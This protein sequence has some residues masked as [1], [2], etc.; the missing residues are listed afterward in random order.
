MKVDWQTIIRGNSFRSSHLKASNDDQS[1]NIE[2]S[3][4][5]TDLLY[6]LTRQGPSQEKAKTHTHTQT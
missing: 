2:L 4:V 5:Q 3:D 6:Q 1:V